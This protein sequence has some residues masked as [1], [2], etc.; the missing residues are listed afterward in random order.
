MEN[1][2]KIINKHDLK[3]FNEKDNHR[4]TRCNCWERGRE[5][6]RCHLNC[7]CFIDNVIYK[8]AIRK[9]DINDKAG[10]NESFHIRATESNWKKRCI[11][12]L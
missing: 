2:M 4:N 8:S 3:I 5:R 1:I 7:N 9:D 10:A 11:Y 6:K 12:G